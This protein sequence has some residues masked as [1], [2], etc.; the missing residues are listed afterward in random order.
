[1]KKDKKDGKKKSGFF[2]WLFGEA[3]RLTLFEVWMPIAKSLLFEWKIN[4]DIRRIARLHQEGAE[5]N[6]KWINCKEGK[7]KP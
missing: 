5:L 6:K 7:Y 3:R 4:R 1:M 2:G